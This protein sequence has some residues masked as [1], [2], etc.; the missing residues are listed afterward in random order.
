MMDGVFELGTPDHDGL[1]HVLML[2]VEQGLNM[3]ANRVIIHFM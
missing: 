2:Q 3:S 1:Y